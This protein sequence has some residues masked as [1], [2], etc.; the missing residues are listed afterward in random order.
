M[1]GARGDLLMGLLLDP[2]NED[3]LSILS[4]LFP[5]KSVGDV[6]SS[7][8][9]ESAKIAIRNIFAPPRLESNEYDDEEGSVLRY[10]LIFLMLQQKGTL[11]HF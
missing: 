10:V 4:R 1:T 7:R 2:N 11:N 9:A 5:G 3:V 6:L 8:A